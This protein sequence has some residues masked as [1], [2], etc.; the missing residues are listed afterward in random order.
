MTSEQKNDHNANELIAQINMK[1]RL[2]DAPAT[3]ELEQ[4]IKDDEND[5]DAYLL[6]SDSYAAFNN[7]DAALDLLILVMR[8][9]RTFKEDAGRKGLINLFEL[10]GAE[11]PLTKSYRRKMFSLMH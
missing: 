2:V 11:H 5:L 3:E 4:R 1:Q 6:L 10:L 7:I 9:D 8:K